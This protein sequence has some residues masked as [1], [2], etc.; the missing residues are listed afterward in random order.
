LSLATARTVQP[1]AQAAYPKPALIVGR[2]L[3]APWSEGTRVINRNFAL[4]ASSRR[5]VRVLSV[6]DQR[7]RALAWAGPPEFLNVEHVFT[8]YGYSWGGMQMAVPHII[9]RLDASDLSRS[10]VAHLFG[11][12]LSLA[13]WLRT[14]GIRVVVHVMAVSLRRSDRLLVQMSMNVFQ[15]WIDAFAVSSAALLPQ[16]A[17]TGIHRS[18]L[19]VVP[20]AINMEAFQPGDGRSVRHSLGVDPGESLVVYLGRLSP[21]RFPAR[22]VASALSQAVSRG[23][24][25]IRLLALSPDRTFDGSENTTEYL[26]ECTRVAERLLGQVPGVTVDVR[27]GSL[28]EESK[29]AL[30][31]ASDAVLLPFAATES[32]E[33][34]LTLIEAMACGANVVATPAAN[35]SGLIRSGINGFVCE[36]PSE[37]SARLVDALDLARGTSRLGQNARRSILKRHSYAAVGEATAQVWQRAEGSRAAAR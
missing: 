24:R 20:H 15:P 25:P 4:A 1:H 33:P 29:V 37:F 19:V 26:L 11:V 35:R 16:L 12:P 23:A 17:S 18:K 36:T 28:D 31:R 32:V 8:R 27:L 34:P 10:G 9:R 13:P 2:A 3:H 5:T 7:L 22:M 30:F 21:Q 6:T 14:R